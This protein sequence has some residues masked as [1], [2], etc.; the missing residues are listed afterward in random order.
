MTYK[1]RIVLD[2]ADRPIRNFRIPATIS[3]KVEGLRM[4]A[5]L[6]ADNRITFADIEARTRTKIGSK[7]KIEP[8]FDKRSL[9]KRASLARQRAG[10]IS[11]VHKRG[12]EAQTEFM[13]NLRTQAQKDNNLA[14]DKDL[15]PAQKA[16]HQLLGLDQDKKSNA[17]TRPDRIS[18]IKR[19]AATGGT[20]AGPSSAAATAG[21]SDP[22]A[23]T[24]GDNDDLT[25]DTDVGEALQEPYIQDQAPEDDTD[26]EG[27]ISSS[28]IDPPDSRHDQPTND[29]EVADLRRALENTRVNFRD[30]AGQEPQPTNPGDNY[31][32][33]WGMLQE[34]FRHIWESR[35]NPGEAPRLRAKDRWTGGISQ[36]YLA[37]EIGEWVGQEESE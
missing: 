27:S 4:E 18:K 3:S 28:L 25:D 7:G 13:D 11:W 10:L 6:R 35:G 20:V 24:S 21:P 9:S 23:A 16:Q 29:D 34:Q 33:Q 37:E 12:R 14:T 1:G 19:T 8:V 32:S 31:F 5:W 17:P 2:F 22:V 36:W 15:D 26:D 30:W